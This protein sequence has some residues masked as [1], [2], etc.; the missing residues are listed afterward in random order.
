MTV[1]KRVQAAHLINEVAKKKCGYGTLSLPLPP[2]FPSPCI[3]SLS[4]GDISQIQIDGTG[5]GFSGALWVEDNTPHNS[6]TDEDF[7]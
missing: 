7:I 5:T 1:I 2:S 6:A 4:W 3:P